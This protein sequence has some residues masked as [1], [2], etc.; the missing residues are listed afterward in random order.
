[1]DFVSRERNEATEHW[2]IQDT[3]IKEDGSRESYEFRNN[4][5]NGLGVFLA[6]IMCKDAGTPIKYY[7]TL[8]SG[9]ATW[10][11]AGTPEVVPTATSL[12]N[13]TYRKLIPDASVT[14]ADVNGNATSTPSNRVRLAITF[15]AGEGTGAI[16][17]MG[18][19]AGNGTSTLGTGILIN[20][21]NHGLI[22][23]EASAVL[24]RV[25]IITL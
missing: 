16:R 23:K 18:I 19:R 21:K 17:E 14:Y 24:E 10:D 20:R 7:M 5:V 11:S 8:G 2:L 22:T 25:V 3:I 15:L 13:E 6:G 12:T 1:M 4:V 9:S